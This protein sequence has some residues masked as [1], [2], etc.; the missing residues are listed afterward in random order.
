MR[1]EI[2]FRLLISCLPFLLSGVGVGISAALN[3][4]Q[5]IVQTKAA[6]TELSNAI[7]KLKF[8]RSLILTSVIP[9]ILI[10]I[11]TVFVDIRTTTVLMASAFGL[12]IPIS[13]I[14]IFKRKIIKLCELRQLLFLR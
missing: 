11:T 13:T 14:I 3:I 1:T 6:D 5:M 7:K 8:T 4:V 2:L 10:A 9:L 12:I